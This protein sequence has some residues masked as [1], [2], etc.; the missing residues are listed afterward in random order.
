MRSVSVTAAFRSTVAEAE[1][2]WY[3]TSR[4]MVWVDELD[5]VVEV[6]EPW[7]KAGGRLV[8]RSG[9]AGR[10][11]VSERVV[12]YEPLS[13]QT[14][15]VEDKSL[16]GRQSVAFTPRDGEVEITLT[17]KYEV[18]QRSLFT[19]LIDPLFIRPVIAASLRTTLSRFGGELAGASGGAHD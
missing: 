12:R 10:G 14:V 5:R 2:C 11:E 13:G 9:P 16:R 3:D 18:K 15:E 8:W 4:W 19:P 7:P 6:D 1:R 17:L